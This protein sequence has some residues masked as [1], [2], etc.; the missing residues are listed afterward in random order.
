[1]ELT[2]WVMNHCTLRLRLNIFVMVHM[3]LVLNVLVIKPW[4]SNWD[5][6]LYDYPNRGNYKNDVYL[7]DQNPPPNYSLN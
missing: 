6:I 7:L 4:Y 2:M 5:N 1:M 3:Q